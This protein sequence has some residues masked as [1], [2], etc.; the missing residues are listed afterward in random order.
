MATA[1]QSRTNL[2]QATQRS[3]PDVSQKTTRVLQR[4]GNREQFLVALNPSKQIQLGREPE[5]AFFSE[6]PSLAIMRKTYGDGFP[7]TWLMP[8]ILDL[9][10]YSN[11]KGTLNEQQAEF[12][13]EAIAQEYYFLK[14][15]ELMLFFYRFKMGK[16]G[17][18]YGNIDPMIITRAL[19]EFC[20]ERI[21]ILEKREAEQEEQE[22]VTNSKNAISPK[23]FCRL[24]GY[25]E[26]DNILDIISHEMGLEK[27]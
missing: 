11:S 15:T 6:A 12:L 24:K 21:A 5:Q 10:A 17:R 23:E 19:D 1:K 18:F 27:K 20:R 25:P 4:Y 7:A 9:V 16:Y 8:Q 13:A 22:R 3:L 14:A 2:P 26:M